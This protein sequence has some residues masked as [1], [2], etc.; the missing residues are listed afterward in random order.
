M[1]AT[2]TLSGRE[3]TALDFAEVNARLMLPWSES[4]YA[5]PSAIGLRVYQI[6]IYKKG[7]KE[8]RYFGSKELKFEAPQFISSFIDGHTSVVQNDKLER[9]WFFDP[10]EL[11]GLGNSV[12]YVRYGTFGFESNFIDA[13]TKITQYR[14]QV[15]DIEEIPLFYEVWS[16]TDR[17]YALL[18]MQ[19]FQGRSC[20]GL[21]MEQ[22]KTAFET[23][24]PGF[25]LRYKKLLPTDKSG[26]VY[27]KAPVRRLTL[28]KHR[29]PTDLTDR[30]YPTKSHTG[31]DFEV[32]LRARRNG[33]LGE[34]GS[35]AGLFETDQAGIVTHDGIA[36]DE[37]VAE[38][39]V[40]RKTRRVGVFGS[41]SD[42]GVIDLSEDI[43][44]GADGHPT[45]ESLVRE[46]GEILKDFY[47]R[48]PS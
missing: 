24:N 8:P 31:V 14:R 21:V 23:A 34:L 37:A 29:A 17:D 32:S 3:A 47:R 16:P 15:F 42:A 38:I 30:Y 11:D 7:A 44:R 33:M 43:E 13:K 46:S 36:F 10:A 12:G 20:V 40:G 39:K 28:I 19:S 1:L 22:L 48:L 25:F 45:F 5:M 2:A 9:S 41:D 27:S 18:S 4:G 35:V 26:S 6:L